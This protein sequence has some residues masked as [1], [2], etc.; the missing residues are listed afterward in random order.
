MMETGG[1]VNNVDKYVLYSYQ[2]AKQL[3]KFCFNHQVKVFTPCSDQI[4]EEKFSDQTGKTCI[5]IQ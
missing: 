3:T 4:M 1:Q 5:L 2:L